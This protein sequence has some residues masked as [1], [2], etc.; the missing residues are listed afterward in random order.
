MVFTTYVLPLLYGLLGTIIGAFR[1]LQEKVRN[2]ELA[3]RDFGLTILGLPLGAVAGIV[4]GLFFSAPTTPVQGGGGIAGALPTHHSW[5]E[6]PASHGLQSFCSLL[7]D[8]M[9]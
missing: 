5:V 1:S 9:P 8:S 7:D 3:P 4:V 2:S 6:S